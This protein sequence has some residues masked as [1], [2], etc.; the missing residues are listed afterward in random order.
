MARSSGPRAAHRAISTCGKRVVLLVRRLREAVERC[1]LARGADRCAVV[2]R[3]RG[4]DGPVRSGQLQAS[5][6]SETVPLLTS[7]GAGMPDRKGTAVR[8][9]GVSLAS[10]T[11]GPGAAA[12]EGAQWKCAM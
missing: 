11:I 12:A 8:L 2:D 1:V 10:G 4:C 5:G 3:R 9:T 6:V 7:A